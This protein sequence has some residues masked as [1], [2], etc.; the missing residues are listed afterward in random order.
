MCSDCQAYKVACCVAVT[1][2]A[3]A[4][5][6]AP[7]TPRTSFTPRLLASMLCTGNATLQWLTRTTAALH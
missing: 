7:A 5:S 6:Q 3:P 4:Q 1:T 2:A